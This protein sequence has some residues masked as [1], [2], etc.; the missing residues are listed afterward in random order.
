[1]DVSE[2]KSRI[3]RAKLLLL[4]STKTNLNNTEVSGIPDSVEDNCLVSTLNP[5]KSTFVIELKNAKIVNK[6]QLSVLLIESL[7]NKHFII[8]K[9]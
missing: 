3:W 5:M 4:T 8:G 9:N 2:K 6:K 1:M 7:P